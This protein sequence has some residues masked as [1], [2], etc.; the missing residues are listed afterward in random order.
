M[1]SG[2]LRWE[3]T[4]YLVFVQI[5]WKRHENEQQIF[6]EWSLDPPESL[7][8]LILVAEL[9][10]GIMTPTTLTF[11]LLPWLLPAELLV[12]LMDGFL[13]P[14]FLSSFVHQGVPQS[15]VLSQGMGTLV[16]GSFWGVPPTRI[17]IT[18]RTDV[19]RGQYASI[20]SR[21]RT[22]LLPF[23]L[24][25][26]GDCVQAHTFMY[27][28]HG[29]PA[30]KHCWWELNVE[31]VLMFFPILSWCV[32]NSGKHIIRVAQNIKATKLNFYTLSLV[33]LQA[34]CHTLVTGRWPWSCRILFRALSAESRLRVL[35]ASPT[36][37]GTRRRCS[38]HCACSMTSIQ[39]PRLTGSL[40]RICL[41]R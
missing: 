19:R 25:G 18:P 39:F 31:F 21:R 24:E 26:A 33:S 3:V 4:S 8:L 9:G 38:R 16:F 32:N 35:G 15:L 10:G 23:V 20:R 27:N 36:T 2:F 30:Q 40:T 22:F 34:C 17:G 5:L 7:P 1:G 12:R 6:C 37:V 41:R 13:P 11:L 29:H 14:A 28:H